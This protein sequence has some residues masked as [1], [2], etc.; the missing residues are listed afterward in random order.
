MTVLIQVD[1]RDKEK[2]QPMVQEKKPRID[3][4]LQSPPPG[5]RWTWCCLLTQHVSDC[6]VL[7][8]GRCSAPWATR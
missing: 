7:A 8:G 4:G 3:P 1:T 2:E 6:D 5:H